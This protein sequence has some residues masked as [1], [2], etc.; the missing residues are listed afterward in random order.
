MIPAMQGAFPSVLAT[1]NDHGIPNISYISQVYYV[2]EHHVALSN[3]FFNK[4]MKNIGSNGIATVS[5]IEP[6]TVQIWYLHLKY[7][8]SETEGDL[9]ENMKM[10]LEAI[11]TMTG[12]QD[13]FHL[14]ASEVF[15]VI[16]VE[17]ALI[18]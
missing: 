7:K 11:A 12:M 1:V 10:Q 16:K 15:E 13:V 18:N 6:T 5:I 17:E 2:D 3:Q 8:R 4:S 9:F 14:R